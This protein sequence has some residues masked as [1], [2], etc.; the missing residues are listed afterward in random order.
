MAT[1]DLLPLWSMSRW[2]RLSVISVKRSS[3]R[4]LFGSA[5][6]ASAIFSLSA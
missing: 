5:A 4:A 2:E 6:K 3:A 1:E